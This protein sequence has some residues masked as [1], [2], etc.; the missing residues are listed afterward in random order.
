MPVYFEKITLYSISNN[1]GRD[2]LPNKKGSIYMTI[3][4][5]IIRLAAQIADIIE[6]IRYADNDEKRALREELSRLRAAKAAL[7]AKLSA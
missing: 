7:E 2:E 3:M 6:D 5:E 1:K 4:N